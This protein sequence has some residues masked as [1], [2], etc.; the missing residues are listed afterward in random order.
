MTDT[1]AAAA[2]RAELIP[3]MRRACLAMPEAEFTQLI[4]D[5]MAVSANAANR[6]LLD[7][8]WPTA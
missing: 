7:H 4:D 8:L 1:I 6:R 5:M 3:R 2:E